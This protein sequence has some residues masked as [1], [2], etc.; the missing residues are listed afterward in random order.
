MVIRSKSLIR[1]ES[2]ICHH[3]EIGRFTPV[4]RHVAPSNGAAERVMGSIPAAWFDSATVSYLADKG[5][6][7]PVCRMTSMVEGSARP[8]RIVTSAIA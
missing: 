3:P 2:L 4:T 1:M 6:N 8:G 7:S 5:V